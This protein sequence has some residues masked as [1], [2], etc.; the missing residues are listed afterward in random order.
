MDDD[1][2]N[3]SFDEDLDEY[4]SDEDSS[5]ENE[6]L[7]DDEVEIAG[8]LDGEFDSEYDMPLYGGHGSSVDFDDLEL[9][10]YV[11]STMDTNLL[12]SGRTLTFYPSKIL[13][14]D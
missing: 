3:D 2:E 8:S 12:L 7:S 9:K 6:D 10:Q 11:M 5:D 1:Y 4:E 14:P 13:N